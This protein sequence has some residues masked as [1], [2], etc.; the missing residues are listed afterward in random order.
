MP[1]LTEAQKRKRDEI[2]EALKEDP[3]FQPMEGRT[4]VESAFAVATET[5]QKAENPGHIPDADEALKQAILV[6]AEGLM[7]TGEPNLEVKGLIL[8]VA[9]SRGDLKAVRKILGDLETM[10]REEG[11][12]YA[13]E[14]YGYLKDSLPKEETNA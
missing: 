10:A 6:E 14:T 5:V 1:E 4:K 3:N 2:A 12:D 8:K 13:A 7:A 9:V 11:I